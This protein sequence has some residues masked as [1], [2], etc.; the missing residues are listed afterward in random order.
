[1]DTPGRVEVNSMLERSEA[2]GTCGHANVINTERLYLYCYSSVAAD[3]VI[4]SWSLPG[5]TCSIRGF[6]G[7]E[8]GDS[9][10]C[11]STNGEDLDRIHRNEARWVITRDEM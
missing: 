10:I 1:M 8:C 9:A 3:V 6:G 5:F 7:C 4:T 11:R 2:L